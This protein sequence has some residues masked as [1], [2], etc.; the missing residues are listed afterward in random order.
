M[1]SNILFE[2][3][4]NVQQPTGKADDKSKSMEYHRQVLESRLKDEQ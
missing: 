4:R 1:S 2:K 3:D